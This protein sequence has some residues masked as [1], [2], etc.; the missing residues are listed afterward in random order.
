MNLID[1]ALKSRIHVEEV[2]KDFQ[3]QVEDLHSQ[4]RWSIKTYVYLIIP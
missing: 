1:S 3:E 2:P 4:V